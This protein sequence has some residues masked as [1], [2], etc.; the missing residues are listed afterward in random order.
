MGGVT[1]MNRR[2]LTTI[3]NRYLDNGDVETAKNYLLTWGIKLK[4][5]DIEK[6]L[7]NLDNAIKN[8]S[9]YKSN[10]VEKSKK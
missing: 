2:E 9:K 7:L 1:T 10:T 8:K 6:E 3:V 5:F 4:G